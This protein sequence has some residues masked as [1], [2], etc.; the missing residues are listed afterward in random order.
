MILD[1]ENKYITD[2]SVV[3]NLRSQDMIWNEL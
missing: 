2:L 3:K 1:F